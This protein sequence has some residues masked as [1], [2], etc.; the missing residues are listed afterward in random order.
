MVKDQRNLVAWLAVW[1]YLPREKR[2]QL[3]R[4]EIA[5]FAALCRSICGEAH[6]PVFERLAETNRQP[7]A[8]TVQCALVAICRVKPEAWDEC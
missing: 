8:A 3:T 7:T 4:E 1:T 5:R 6:A 2:R